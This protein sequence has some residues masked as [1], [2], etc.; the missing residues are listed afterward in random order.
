MAAKTFTFD[1]GI[2]PVLKIRKVVEKENGVEHVIQYIS[3]SPNMLAL[4]SFT[5]QYVAYLQFCVIIK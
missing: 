2:F 1:L 3:F 4:N 5:E